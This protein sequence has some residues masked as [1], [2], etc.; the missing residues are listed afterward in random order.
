MNLLQKKLVLL[1]PVLTNFQ[2][3]HYWKTLFTCSLTKEIIWCNRC[4]F[5]LCRSYYQWCSINNGGITMAF[6]KSPFWHKMCFA[7]GTAIYQ[8]TAL[9]Q[10][11][12]LSTVYTNTCWFAAWDQFVNNTLLDELTKVIPVFTLWFCQNHEA[13]SQQKSSRILSLSYKV[14]IRLIELVCSCSL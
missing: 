9:K 14:H 10:W 7:L 1:V 11:C 5:F 4:F 2:V 8:K 12:A 13:A 6:L 3:R